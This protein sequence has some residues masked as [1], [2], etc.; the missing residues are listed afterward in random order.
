M[1]RAS[2]SQKDPIRSLIWLSFSAL[3]IDFSKSRYLGQK[4][5]RFRL[6]NTKERRKRMK[7]KENM[8]T[9]VNHSRRGNNLLIKGV[10]G[11]IKIVGQHVTGRSKHIDSIDIEVTGIAVSHDRLQNKKK[12]Y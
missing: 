8:A 6:K 2:S 11:N 5:F 9:T 12:N 10:T 1:I 4:Q 7:E 3:N